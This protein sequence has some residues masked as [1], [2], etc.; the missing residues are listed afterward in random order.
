MP[1]LKELTITPPFTPKKGFLGLP[2]EL[3]D[4]IYTFTLVQPIKWSR[5]HK[6]TCPHCPRT[7]TVFERPLFTYN[8]QPCACLRRT[9]LAL[10]LANRQIH[11]EAAPVFWAENP[12]CFSLAAEFTAGIITGPVL[13][14]AYRLLLRHVSVMSVT[15]AF[16]QPYGGASVATKEQTALLWQALMEC[17]G[18]ERLEVHPFYGWWH[19]EQYGYLGRLGAAL[20]LLRSFG[21]EKL[22]YFNVGK[23]FKGQWLDFPKL[24]TLYCLSRKEVDV[25]S[26]TSGGAVRE[27]IREFETN[28]LVHVR[29]AIECDLLGHRYRPQSLN[30]PVYR[31]FSYKLG[32]GLD[33]R[34]PTQTLQLRDCTTTTVQLF[35]LPLSAETRKRNARERYIHDVLQRKQGKPTMREQK[36]SEAV[37]VRRSEN[38]SK[39]K[40]RE[41]RERNNE[42]TQKFLR[43]ID[44]RLWMAQQARMEEVDRK[45]ALQQSLEAAAELKRLER[46]KVSR[47]R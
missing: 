18:L 2:R 42:R 14:P 37:K 30:S 29:Y 28:F 5:R 44:D 20:P 24:Q 40:L 45:A 21:W 43:Q 27:S 23:D 32:E 15:W 34:N 13:R 1:P 8:V 6:P 39:Q 26:F 3:R 16:N 11:A 36:M 47:P 38:K 9:G 4:V 33:D 17:R 12:H 46:K 7:C 10:L 35:G 25:G 22:N 31:S 41:E 19:V